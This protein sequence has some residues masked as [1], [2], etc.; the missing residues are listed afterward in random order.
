MQ[1]RLPCTVQLK[2]TLLTEP[3][4]EPVA[5]TAVTEQQLGGVG[6]RFS[7]M[8]PLINKYIAVCKESVHLKITVCY[9]NTLVSVLCV[10]LCNM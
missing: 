6:G 10:L 7:H 8:T 1:V 4:S 3:A 2:A 5:A 9:D